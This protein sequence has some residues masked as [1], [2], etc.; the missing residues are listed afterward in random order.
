MPPN[1]VELEAFRVK[2]A[3]GFAS[4]VLLLLVVSLLLVVG[5]CAGSA[6]S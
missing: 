1:S 6:F 5:G 2:P 3:W 4:A